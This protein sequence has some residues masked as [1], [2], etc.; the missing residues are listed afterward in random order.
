MTDQAQARQVA[1]EEILNSRRVVSSAVVV[2]AVTMAIALV[3]YV[4]DWI[5]AVSA[6]EFPEPD[7]WLGMVG[8]AGLPYAVV[9]TRRL[10]RFERMLTTREREAVQAFQDTVDNA[11]G[12][13]WQTDAD[14]RI[15]YSSH[16]VHAMLGHQPSE[17][18]GR[19][20]CELISDGASA[21]P[22]VDPGG[23]QE[24]ATETRHTDG[25]V[26]H[27]STTVAPMFDETGRTV[28]YRGFTADVTVEKVAQI[29]QDE[30]QRRYAEARARI[31]QA[32]DDPEAMYVVLQP[33]VDIDGQRIAGMEAL[34]RFNAEPKRTPDLWFAEAWEVGLGIDLELHA[35]DLAC[36]RLPELP[37][38]GY[39]SINLS[40]QTLTD[41][42]LLDL[43]SGLGDQARRIVVEVTEHTAIDDY[44][45]V[46][47]V[48]DRIRALGARLAVDDAGAGYASMQHI[49]RLRPD[50]IK[51]DRSIIADNDVDPARFALI[52][53][54]ANFAVSLGM[55]VIAEGVETPGELA[56]LTENQICHA[57]GYYLARPAVEPLMELTPPVTSVAA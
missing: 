2:L 27:L 20:V 54:M 44:G 16:G 43:L 13:I 57:Q 5:D 53:A 14:M 28:G 4:W 12:W 19:V 17:V 11:H 8:L 33:I 46:G 24:L 21:R 1:T 50:I 39:L 22:K 47:D 6:G 35:I 30:K 40:A 31:E 37:A 51:L 38:H 45:V 10:V 48:L 3:S 18:I 41:P 26:R 55:V 23:R 29:A 56:A 15:T 32:L 42:R 36:R 52:G 49:L 7:E 25:S 9:V 34:A